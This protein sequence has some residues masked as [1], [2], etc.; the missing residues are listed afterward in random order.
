[1]RVRGMG[2][3]DHHGKARRSS[4]QVH[5]TGLVFNRGRMANL[6]TNARSIFSLIA[7]S[8]GARIMKPGGAVVTSAASLQENACIKSFVLRRYSARGSMG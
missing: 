6:N 2:W 3:E 1:M 7:K 8:N 5:R 4:I